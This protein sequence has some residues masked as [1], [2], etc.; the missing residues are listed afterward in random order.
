M[1]QRQAV[2]E[3]QH[4]HLHRIHIKL[5]RGHMCHDNNRQLRHRSNVSSV[6]P[7]YSSSFSS[8]RC[9]HTLSTTLLLVQQEC[10]LIVKNASVEQIKQAMAAVEIPLTKQ[11]LRPNTTISD[12]QARRSRDALHTGWVQ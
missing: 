2:E 4:T 1:S 12:S 9:F 8:N 6:H 10:T 7:L 3:D 11:I 5:L